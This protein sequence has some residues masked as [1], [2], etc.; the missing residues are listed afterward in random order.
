M[1]NKRWE[2]VVPVSRAEL[3]SCLP[4]LQISLA[5]SQRTREIHFES[6]FLSLQ[7]GKCSESCFRSTQPTVPQH[8]TCHLSYTTLAKGFNRLSAPQSASSSSYCAAQDISRNFLNRG[9]V[10]SSNGLQDSNIGAE[11]MNRNST[12]LYR[13]ENYRVQSTGRSNSFLGKI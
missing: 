13:S 1:R 7:R 10:P 6:M 5:T 9:S 4:T 12:N 8:G 11:H 2:M 3:S